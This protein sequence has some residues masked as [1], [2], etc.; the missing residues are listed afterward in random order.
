MPTRGELETARSRLL[1]DVVAPGLRVLFCGINPGL[2]SA[3]WAP[4]RAA[5]QPVLAGPAPAGFT[6]RLLAPGEQEQ[7]LDLGL[8]I[9]NVVARADRRRRTS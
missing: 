5:R 9:T 7:L 3:A 6:P 4:L 8:G 1:P 2:Y